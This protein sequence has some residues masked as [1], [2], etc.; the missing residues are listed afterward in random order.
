MTAVTNRTRA[1]GLL[2]TLALGALAAASGAAEAGEV[3]GTVELLVIRVDTSDAPGAPITTDEARRLV[4]ETSAAYEAF[5]YGRVDLTATVTPTLR[6]PE[7]AAEYGQGKVVGVAAQTAARGEGYDLDAYDAVV[8]ICHPEAYT[9]RPATWGRSFVLYGQ[10]LTL[11]TLGHELGHTMGLGHAN[12]WRART[13]RPSGPGTSSEYG[14]PWTIMGAG[15]GGRSHFVAPSKARLGWL[16]PDEVVRPAT[17]GTYRVHALEDPIEDGLHALRIAL[18]DRRDLWL[19]VRRDASAGAPPGVLFN[20]AGA[21]LQGPVDLLDMNPLTPRGGDDSTLALGRTYAVAATG[22]YVTPIDRAPDWSWIDVLVQVDV[23]R[24]APPAPFEVEATPRQVAPGGTITFRAATTDPD[25]DPLV[26]SWD[27]DDREGPDRGPVAAR[28]FQRAG[29]Y[30]VRCQASD[31]RGGTWTDTV[32]IEVGSPAGPYVE[33]HVRRA[34]GAPVEGAVVTATGAKTYSLRHPYAVTDS[35]GFYALTASMGG[36]YRTRLEPGEYELA[37]NRF[38]LRVEPAFEVPVSVTGPAA[39]LDF[40]AEP[41]YAPPA[42]PEGP[43]R[44]EVDAAG[45]FTFRGARPDGS[46]PV[47]RIDWGDGTT[48]RSPTFFFGEQTT[49]H[50]WPAPGTY[51]VRARLVDYFGR[52]SAWSEPLWVTV[53][54]PLPAPRLRAPRDGARLGCSQPR[55]AWSPVEA[56]EEVFYRVQV[57]RPPDFARG[58][59]VVRAGTRRPVHVPWRPLEPG[60]YAWRVQA[61]GRTRGPGAWSEVRRFAV[62]RTTAGPRP[63]ASPTP[64]PSPSPRSRPRPSPSVSPTPSPNPEAR[65]Q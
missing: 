34:D 52:R 57:S 11:R 63:S 15:R 39:G 17:S 31:T 59:L 12:T 9:G 48:G 37:A 22:T 4:E 2:G 1:R 36:S 13:T 46:W 51:E 58:D 38:G 28:L 55:L 54:D 23:E 35:R 21:D 20:R 19:E 29:R 8:T 43:A 14:N 7:L 24:N 61:V 49:E 42:R 44:L 25:G 45:A 27:F 60:R 6:L 32:V 26:Y 62:V 33:G 56:D 5:S 30:A 53:A 65:E 41:F 18:T 47:L 16:R 40:V 64:S 3:E 50:A 10:Y